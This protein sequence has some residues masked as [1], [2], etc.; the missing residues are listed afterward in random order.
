MGADNPSLIVF[1]D[2]YCN[3]CNKWVDRILR[4]EK[5]ASFYF[6]P[7]SGETAQKK[8]PR[9][10]QQEGPDAIILQEGERFLTGAHAALRIARSMKWP[11]RALAI[12][13]I[14]PSFLL[15]RGYKWVAK[16][17]YRWY[18]KREECRL[19]SPEERERFL[20]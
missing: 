5:G 16:N 3:L 12:L 4:N 11:Y 13:R 1:F 20:D 9:E 15:E 6:A 17:R 8:I 10:L 14:L 7:L 18:G 2:G 19:P